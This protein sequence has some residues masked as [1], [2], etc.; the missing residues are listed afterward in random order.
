MHI[1]TIF[2]NHAATAIFNKHISLSSVLT[3]KEWT[4]CKVMH[5][6]IKM[7]T[8]LGNKFKLFPHGKIR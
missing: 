8:K 7:E 4:F 3:L 6:F 1:Y 2:P 5:A